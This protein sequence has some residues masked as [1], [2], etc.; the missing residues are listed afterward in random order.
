MP[1][2]DYYATFEDHK[3]V[4]DWLFSEGTADIYELSSEFEKPLTKFS[5]SAQV[6]DQFNRTY[7][8]GKLWSTVYLQLVVKN[9]G[10]DFHPT[11]VKLDPDQSNGASYKYTAEGFG[12][13]QLY[14]SVPR[15]NEL[16]DSHTNHF[17]LKGAMKWSGITTTEQEIQ[18][19]DFKAITSFSSSLNRQ[20]RKLAVVKIRSRILTKGALALW[21]KG[22]KLWPFDKTN[23]KLDLLT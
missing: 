6:L 3:I 20:I 18:K 8:G 7:K 23:S 21:D 14:L 4:L 17:T 2:C 9:A 10:I 12:L 15:D 5:N 1:N 13:I 16:R 22:F 11:Y 19:I